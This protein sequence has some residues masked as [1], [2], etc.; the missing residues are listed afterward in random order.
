M[1]GK[2]DDQISVTGNLTRDPE[3]KWSGDGTAY[4]RINLARNRRRRNQQGEWEDDGEAIYIQAT[5]FWQQAEDIANRAK[6]GSRV[7]VTGRLEQPYVWTG[8]DGKNHA[9]VCMTID[10]YEIMQPRQQQSMPG[11]QIGQ[12]PWQVTPQTQATA[13]GQ[14]QQQPQQGQQRAQP[15]QQQQPPQQQPQYDPWATQQGTPP[16]NPQLQ[17][18]D[19]WGQQQLPP[20]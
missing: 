16:Q 9:V 2:Q 10:H 11:N 4:T 7:Y 5:A 3:I 13:Q 18:D 17:Q 20:F 12:D 1:S 14:P 19:P 8:K 6:K 15:V